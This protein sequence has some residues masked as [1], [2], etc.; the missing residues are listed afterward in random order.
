MKHPNVSIHQASAADWQLLG[1]LQLAVSP[2]AGQGLR[3]WL[4]ATLGPLQL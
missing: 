3:E 2:D 1:E 4:A